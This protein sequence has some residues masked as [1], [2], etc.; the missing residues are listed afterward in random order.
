MRK[1]MGVGRKEIHIKIGIILKSNIGNEILSLSYFIN[2]SK[3]S[4]K[5]HPAYTQGEDYKD[6]AL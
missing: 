5:V 4:H 6:H 2:S 3:L 1:G